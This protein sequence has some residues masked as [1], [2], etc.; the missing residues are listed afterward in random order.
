MARARVTIAGL[1]GLT[2]LIGN[3]TSAWAETAE[4]EHKA[5]TDSSNALPTTGISAKARSRPWRPLAGRP[6]CASSRPVYFE[7]KLGPSQKAYTMVLDE[8]QGTGR[9]YDRLYVDAD[10]NR[11]L[12]DEKPVEGT[13]RASR[14][15]TRSQF[16]AAEVRVRYGGE[17]LPWTFSAYCYSYQSRGG[18]PTSLQ[19]S[20][21]AYC[22]GTVEVGGKQVKLAVVDGDSNGCFNN[23]YAMPRGARSTRGR[24]YASG[25]W[26]LVDANSDGRY[27]VDSM[28]LEAFGCGRHLLVDGECYE[29]KI[30]SC[31]RRLSV[32]PAKARC[33]LLS[34]RGGGTFSAAFLTRSYGM[35]TVRSTGEPVK[36]PAGTYKLYACSFEAKD[37][38]GTVWR[39]TGQGGS[40]GQLIRVVA[41]KATT[42]RFG[43]PLKIGVSAS[44]YPSGSVGSLRPGRTLRLSLE[45]KGQAGEGYSGRSVTKSGGRLDKPKVKIT[46]RGGKVVATGS[47][48]YG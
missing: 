5:W 17:D 15:Y 40:S 2:L 16:N 4:L 32:E 18:V 27:D 19:V 26:I 25:D 45:I 47:F 21:A 30:S 23:Y 7:V 8:S 31:G 38:A 9:G 44:V 48:E 11:D 33:G 39:A 6:R 29:V 34:R 28:G 14:S 35:L 13:V 10:G 36:V 20:S 41:G 3:A 24:L 43:P 46:G 1:V 12:R 37:D 22:E 42:A